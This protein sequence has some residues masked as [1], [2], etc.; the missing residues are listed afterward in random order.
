MPHPSV[1]WPTVTEVRLASWN[2]LHGRSVTDGA[3]DAANLRRGAE[4]LDADV[5]ALQEVDRHQHRSGHAHQTSAVADALGATWSLFVPS[6]WGEP[7]GTW[8]PVASH[9]PDDGRRAAYGI[10]LVTRL[11]VLDRHVLRFDPAPFG[12]PL[13][14]PG[15]GLVK[16]DDEPRVAVAAVL[17]GPSGVFTVVATHLSFVPGFNMRQLRQLVRWAQAMPGP[18]VLLGDLNLPGRLPRIVSG[19]TQLTRLATYPSWKPRVQFDH[20]LA[21]GMGPH[22]VVRAQ[23]LRLPVSDHNALSLTLRL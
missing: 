20:A 1:R 11:R 15:R 23:S 9:E 19:W 2:L 6:V 22:Q 18:R 5:V 21:D 4:L 17:D 10:G 16:V 12:M 14:V 8:Q 3:V 13:L 7:G